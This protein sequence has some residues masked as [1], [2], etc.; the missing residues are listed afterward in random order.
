[1]PKRKTIEPR[2][3]AETTT[4]RGDKRR[5][6]GERTR[7]RIVGEALRIASTEGIDGVTMGSVAEAAGVSKG[8][9]AL[10]FGNREGLQVAVLNAG[11]RVWTETVG[12]RIDGE[13]DAVER[14][15][16][17]C[18]GWLDVVERRE[19]PGG[20]LMTATASEFR[21]KPGGVHDRLS[22]LRWQ[23]RERLRR[24]VAGVLERR[25]KPKDVEEAVNDILAYQAFANV[26]TFLDGESAF[27]HARR[28]TE[29]LIEGLAARGR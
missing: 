22:E 14:L 21:T 20:C 17:F 24:L 25:G 6:K 12:R 9:L 19:L 7:G 27:D 28:R 18:L 15:R 1:M 13:R 3:V 26:A 16:A 5:E 11:E 4:G 23:Y 29:E 10:L 8:H 2:A